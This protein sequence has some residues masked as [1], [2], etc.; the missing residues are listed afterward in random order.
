[1]KRRE[2]IALLGGAAAAWPMA[3][4]AQQDGR[5]RLVGVVGGFAEAEMRPLLIALRD[6]LKEL[7]WTEGRNLSIDARLGRGNFKRM[8]DEAGLLIGL[9]PDVIVAQGTPG[10]TAVR[11]HSRTV[12]VVF[13]FVA[14]P[15]RTGLIESLARPG[16]YATG[17][18]NFEFTIGGKW[19]E[20]LKELNPR[21]A[22]VTLISNPA[23][24]AAD[25]FSQFIAATA[26]SAGLD[27]VIASVRNAT[28]IAVVITSASR[29]PDAG[30]IVVPD[31]LTTIHRELIIGLAAHHRLPAV[32]PFRIFPAEGGLISYGLDFAEIYRQAAVYVDR[33]LRGAQPS[34]LPVQAPNKFELVINLKTAKALGL[35]VPPNLLAR[36]D[37]VIE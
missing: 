28:D 20:L 32:Y 23:N 3:A 2:F 1:M 24:P 37:E 30:L 16:G 26:R 12:P 15:V 11:E 14:D 6:K 31:S 10:L 13:L 18:T 19:L 8:A 22:H 34:D 7:G 21:V 36:A 25:Q 35:D 27:L 4:R 5:V 33:I 17:F 29:Q 9:N